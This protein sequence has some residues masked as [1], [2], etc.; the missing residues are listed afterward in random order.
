[1]GETAVKLAFFRLQD[2]Q[3]MAS[4]RVRNLKV[5]APKSGGGSVGPIK[6]QFH[7][8]LSAHFVGKSSGNEVQIK[9]ER[10]DGVFQN[11][12]LARWAKRMRLGNNFQLSSEGSVVVKQAGVYYVYAQIN[13]LDEHDVNAF[14]VMVNNDPYL[15]CTTMTHT[16]HSV[17]KA[18]TCYTGGVV[19]LESDDKISVRDLET[20]RKSVIR[21]AH[22]FFGL[23]QLSGLDA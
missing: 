13:Y 4:S 12:E 16:G 11:W 8:L 14:Q 1:M 10:E 20:G 2:K 22:T 19:F 9:N 23:I 6:D 7:G 15:L 18:N 5:P 17:S 3:Q 21:A